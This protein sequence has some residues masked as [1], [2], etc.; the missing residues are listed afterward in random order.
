[1]LGEAGLG[2]EGAERSQGMRS[3]LGLFC[4]VLLQLSSPRAAVPEQ[5]RQVCRSPKGRD[6][7]CT[8]SPGFYTHPETRRVEILGR[9]IHYLHCSMRLFLISPVPQ[10]EMLTIHWGVETPSFPFPIPFYSAASSQQPSTQA[11]ISPHAKSLPPQ[12]L[13]HK[14]PP[15]DPQPPSLTFI[16]HLGQEHSFSD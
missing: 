13:L 14:M 5:E 2:R 6:E 16:A 11:P 1:M 12:P 7:I 3:L 4:A 10:R 8:A 9:R 15:T